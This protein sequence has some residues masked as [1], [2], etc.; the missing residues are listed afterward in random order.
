MEQTRGKRGAEM[1]GASLALRGPA[2]RGKVES[3][4]TRLFALLNRL[5]SILS[6]IDFNTHIN[7][8]CSKSY[9]MEG[10]RAHKG[11]TLRADI[12]GDMS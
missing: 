12:L 4:A 6:L 10:L 8:A 3:H 1:L 5:K 7:G 9:G 11:Q 2:M